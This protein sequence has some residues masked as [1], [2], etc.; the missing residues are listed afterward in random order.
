MGTGPN[1]PHG[2]YFMSAKPFR[3]DGLDLRIYRYIGDC[4]GFGCP[5]VLIARPVALEF[6]QVSKDSPPTIHLP[7]CTHLNI[8][9][10]K[11]EGL[12]EAQP[13]TSQERG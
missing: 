11:L 13:F 6:G 9:R 7:A 12:Q 8:L 4:D 5:R 2:A 10:N 1:E 3:D